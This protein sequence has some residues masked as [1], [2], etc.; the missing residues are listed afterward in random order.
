MDGGPLFLLVRSPLPLY[1]CHEWGYCYF[2][3]N[4][5]WQDYDWRRDIFFVLAQPLP[6]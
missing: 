6:L 2:F 5:H 4:M 1:T 3:A